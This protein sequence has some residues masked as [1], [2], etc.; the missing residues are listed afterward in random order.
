MR[1]LLAFDKFKDSLTA[2][3]ACAAAAAA[4]QGTHPDWTIDSCPLADGGE[5]FGAILTQA[6]GGEIITASVTGPRG[7]S[8]QGAIGLVPLERIPAP[9]PR[10]A[11]DS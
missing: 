4:L 11:A 3:E 6:T 10:S 9:G 5:G 8:V 2:P 7:S 1:A